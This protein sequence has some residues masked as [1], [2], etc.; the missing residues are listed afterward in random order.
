VSRLHF[1]RRPGRQ[2]GQTCLPLQRLLCRRPCLSELLRCSSSAQFFSSHTGW[3]L[4]RFIRAF[5]TVWQ[6]WQGNRFHPTTLKSLGLMIHLNHATHCDSPRAAHVQFRVLHL[7]GIHDVAIEFCA[8]KNKIPEYTQLLRRGLYPS[9]STDVR[10]CATFTLLEQ[11]HILSLVTK[12]S[13]YDFY[14]AI[15]KMTDNTG[16]EIPKTRYRQ[17]SRMLLQWRHLKMLKRAGRGHDRSGVQG[18][19]PGELAVRCP[20]CPYP[21]INLPDDWE[22]KGAIHR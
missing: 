2:T 1:Q 18:T 22:T 9:T 17:L 11:L 13:T 10:T 19:K 15:E 6:E 16:V 12:G 4:D 8:C 5:L 7:N 21:G 14:R 3:C 20:H